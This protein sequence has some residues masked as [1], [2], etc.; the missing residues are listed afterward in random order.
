MGYL[1]VIWF[2]ALNSA[3]MFGKVPLGAYV[4]NL[5]SIIFVA[6]VVLP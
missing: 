5:L 6:A 3:A 2:V 1:L 4:A